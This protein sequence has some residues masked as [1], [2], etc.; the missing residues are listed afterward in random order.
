MEKKIIESDIA[1]QDTQSAMEA[2]I[3]CDRKRLSELEQQIMDLEFHIRAQKELVS[4][5]SIQPTSFVVGHRKA[6]QP[7]KRSGKSCRR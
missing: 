4:S 2:Q 3:E 6:S 7:L 5:G 1:L